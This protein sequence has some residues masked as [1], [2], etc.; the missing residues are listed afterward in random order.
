[1]NRTCRAYL[2]QE[3]PSFPLPG[4][5]EAWMKGI[6]K[7]TGRVLR[8][9]CVLD[10]ENDE[11]SWEDGAPFALIISGKEGNVMLMAP[12]SRIIKEFDRLIP[13]KAVSAG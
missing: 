10:T 8:E 11:S 5:E 9:I 4:D 3:L 2:I 12:T 13:E 6:L 1:M 7:N